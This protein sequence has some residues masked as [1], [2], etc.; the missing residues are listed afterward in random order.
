MFNKI[1]SGMTY[2]V[3]GHEFNGNESTIILNK[4]YRSVDKNV[5]PEA[6][7]NLSLYFC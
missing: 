2:C 7:R 4:V 3:V 1:C 6:H 5:K